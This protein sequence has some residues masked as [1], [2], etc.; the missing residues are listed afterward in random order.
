MKMGVSCLSGGKLEELKTFAEPGVTITCEGVGLGVAMLSS[1]EGL[2]LAMNSEAEEGI[3]GVAGRS[4]QWTL[5]HELLR[6]H[7]KTTNA[8]KSAFTCHGYPRR[9][10]GF[11]VVRSGPPPCRCPLDSFNLL[12]HACMHVSLIDVLGTRKKVHFVLDL[13]AGGELF[14]LVDSDGRMTEDL[15][16]HYFRQLVSAVRI[17]TPGV[18]HRDIKPENLLSARGRA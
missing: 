3:I 13:A 12:A 7:P 1:R 9:P 4:P 6:F 5:A 16:R 2:D 8:R 10:G 15:A 17:A 18:Y 11:R 14:S